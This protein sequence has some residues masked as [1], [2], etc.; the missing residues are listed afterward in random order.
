MNNVTANRSMV[1]IKISAAVFVFLLTPL[2][3]N[4][5]SP[6]SLVG[7][8]LLNNPKLK[9]LEY[10]TKSAEFRA[11]GAASLPAPT[12]GIEFGE[13]PVGKYNLFNDA[14]SNK[15]SFSQMFMP[16]GKLSAMSEVENK[17][18]LVVN[19]NYYIYKAYLIGQVKMS[20]YSVW[21]IER[22]IE[23]Q[24][25]T[26]EL[27]NELINSQQ[28][29]YSVNK[30]SQAD[31][32][33]LKSETASGNT[34]VLVLLR[35]KEAEVYRLNKLLG[36]ELLRQDIVTDSSLKN[37]EIPAV[38]QKELEDKLISVN[39]SLKQMTSM[40]EMNKAMITANQK[41]RIPDLMVQ[42][43]FMRQPQ[44]MFLTTKT[45]L[46]MLGMEEAKTEYMYSLMVSVTL[47]FAPWSAGKYKAKEEELAAGIRAVEYE[48][49]DM[50]REMISRL[51]VAFTKL[52]TAEDMIKLY[53]TDVI[54]LYE[55][56]TS[57]QLSAYQ[58]SRVNAGVVIDSYR[59][60]LMQQMNYYM[61]QADYQMAVA[62]IEMMVGKELKNGEQK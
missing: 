37:E 53:S 36:R 15:L 32:L 19:D 56:A 34:Q 28:S 51:N 14:F 21:I 42:A 11:D 35:Q 62:E 43:M 2:I 22:K 58:N 13:V 41:D 26:I 20:Y 18:A 12:I 33:T 25:K 39:P 6:D 17:N 46:A 3:L 38:A 23:I 49:I 5:Q 8:A 10:K 9:S 61:A 47:P 29:L 54:P 30:I 27:Y 50:Q 45:D 60:L 52:R 59:M 55:Q 1:R 16:G 31:V 57:A 4:A 24:K 48:K 44:G 7:E 40:I